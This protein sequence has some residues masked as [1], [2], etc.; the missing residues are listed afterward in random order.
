MNSVVVRWKVNRENFPPMTFTSDTR[1]VLITDGP[2][3]QAVFIM[4]G[5]NKNSVGDKNKAYKTIDD[6]KKYVNITSK[7]W[8]L[9]LVLVPH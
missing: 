6:K 5:K 8:T 1:L 2:T 3:Y 9:I 4:H 7:E